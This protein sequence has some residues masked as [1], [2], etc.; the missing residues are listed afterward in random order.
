MPLLFN[1]FLCILFSGI[2]FVEKNN[3]S[4]ESNVCQKNEIESQSSPCLRQALTSNVAHCLI[5][6]LNTDTLT[7][8]N[9]LIFSGGLDKCQNLGPQKSMAE[10]GAAKG[11]VWDWSHREDGGD[12]TEPLR[13]RDKTQT[14]PL[15]SPAI[16]GLGNPI[17]TR[18]LSSGLNLRSHP[19]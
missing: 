13:P 17:H 4:S 16:I 14:T 15:S 8:H 19:V 6:Q 3:P 12:T 18:T 5:V 1:V 11:C 10:S 9:G 2:S 7:P